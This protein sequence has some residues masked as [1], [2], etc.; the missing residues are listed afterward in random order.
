MP[1]FHFL[2]SFQLTCL[3]IPIVAIPPLHQSFHS[4]D[5]HR[6]LS[7]CQLHLPPCL[8]KLH[9]SNCHLL[10]HTFY[11]LALLPLSYPKS[12]TPAFLSAH[13]QLNKW[14]KWVD[15]FHFKYS[16]SD[17]RLTSHASLILADSV[18]DFSSHYTRLLLH[19]VSVLNAPTPPLPSL[20]SVDDLILLFTEKIKVIFFCQTCTA[21]CYTHI[22]SPPYCN[23]V[24]VL[25]I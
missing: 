14:F 15:F 12:F 16:I 25:L 2:L 24:S 4:L 9:E 11:L 6:F 21:T 23:G 20:L 10:K 19:T 5:S 7:I 1:Q 17:L 18:R 8:I 22:I 13:K 3:W